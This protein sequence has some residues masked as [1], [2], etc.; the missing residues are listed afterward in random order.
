MKAYW[1]TVV[2]VMATALHTQIITKYTY[3]LSIILP[4]VCVIPHRCGGGRSCHALYPCGW[5]N[6]VSGCVNTCVILAED[7]RVWGG[8]G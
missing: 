8:G 2:R 4:F 6:T 5:M 1:V 3:V 7:E